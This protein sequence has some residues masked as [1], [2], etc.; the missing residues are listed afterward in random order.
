MIH[1]FFPVP[2]PPLV[3]LW[4]FH[5]TCNIIR[6]V[7]LWFSKCGR[8][9]NLFCDNQVLIT[10]WLKNRIRKLT[11]LKYSFFWKCIG[12]VNLKKFSSNTIFTWYTFG[13]FYIVKFNYFSGR[14]NKVQEM[15]WN[16]FDWSLCWWYWK[17][18]W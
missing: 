5:Y 11:F 1:F 10:Y 6:D 17:Y 7:K 9:V 18:R 14:P 2:I 15:F 16:I 13:K 8:K 4:V 3:V 12:T